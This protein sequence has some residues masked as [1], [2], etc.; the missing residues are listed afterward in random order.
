MKILLVNPPARR[1]VYQHSPSFPL[2]LG[3]IAS[4]LNKKHHTVK[5]FDAE[6]NY[7]TFPLIKKPRFPLSYMAKNWNRYFIGLKDPEHPIW[8]EIESVILD[9]IPDIVGIT[10]RTIDLPSAH[11]ITEIIK[12]NNPKIITVIGGPA[13]TIQPDKTLHNLSVDFAIRGEGE[14][15]FLELVSKIESGKNNFDEIAGLSYRINDRVLHNNARILISDINEIPYP[16]RTSLLYAPLLPENNFK[17]LMGEI[18]GSRGCPYNCAFCA[19]HSIWGSRKPRMRKPENIID[20]IIELKNKFHVTRFI[21]WDD[22]FTLNK[23]RCMEICNEI[24]NRNLHIEWIC[25]ARAD[26]IDDELCLLL[27]KA[28]CIEIQLGVESG[29]ECILEL[30]VKKITIKDIINSADI[31]KRHGLKLHIFLLIGF[32]GEQIGDLIATM[33]I[34]PKLLPN[35]VELSIF[36]PYPGSDAYNSLMKKGENEVMEKEIS[37]A[38]FLNIK[39]NFNPNYDDIDFNGISLDLLKICDLYNLINKGL[40]KIT[41]VNRSFSFNIIRERIMKFLIKGLIFIIIKKHDLYGR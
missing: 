25:L 22:L 31:I 9:E 28:G 4:F 11:M 1:F 14:I 41:P 6:W 18:I 8:K 19:N 29:S 20:E 7:Q 34:I 36:A 10:A 21:F 24:I 32:P 26:T 3:Y 5:I 2:G 30:M 38:D 13:A 37:Y 27:K 33:N 17:S 16:D 40:I 35:V 15:T 39:Y 23:H 12:K